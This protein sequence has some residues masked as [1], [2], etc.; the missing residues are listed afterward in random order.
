MSITKNRPNTILLGGGLP[1]AQGAGSVVNEYST[2]VITTPGMLVEKYT[3]SDK[4]KI[5]PH[6]VAG[7]VAAPMV[8]VEKIEWNKGVDDTYAVGEMMNYVHLR[9]GSTFWGIVPTGNTV[10]AGTFLQSNGDGKLKV[11]TATAAAA[12]VARF[13][14]LENIGLTAADTRCRVEVL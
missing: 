5:R 2:G 12:N 9:K 8:A 10:T 14:S 11:A 7:D 4:I 6:S 1:G 3:V 13:Q